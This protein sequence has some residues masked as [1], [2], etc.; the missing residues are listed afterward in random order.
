MQDLNHYLKLARYHI[1][2]LGYV[3]F[4]KD[5]DII[6]RI[7]NQIMMCDW[8]N[9]PGFIPK[10]VEWEIIRILKE[11][12]REKRVRSSAKKAYSGFTADR[13]LEDVDRDD[14]RE[15]VKNTDLLNDVQRSIVL[16]RLDNKKMLE[17][18]Q[19]HKVTKQ[20]VSLVLKDAVEILKCLI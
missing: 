4:L 15:Y 11:Q 8:K 19:E 13:Q 14:F 7:A 9:K 2:K 3:S 12:R 5:E 10:S 20:Y 16:S 6:G 17:I 1:V 18:A